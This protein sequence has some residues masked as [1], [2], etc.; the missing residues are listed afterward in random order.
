MSRARK[1]VWLTNACRVLAVNVQKGV[2]K[3]E[4]VGKLTKDGYAIE[5][6]VKLPPLVQEIAASAYKR[7]RKDLQ[8]EI[9]RAL[10]Q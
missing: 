9:K 6:V 8:G 4:Y 1:S 2:A 10:E 5:R 7:G 3:I